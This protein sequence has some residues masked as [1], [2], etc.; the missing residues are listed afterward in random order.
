MLRCLEPENCNSKRNKREEETIYNKI[1]G[2]LACESDLERIK[3]IAYSR[4]ISI[5]QIK[6]AKIILGVMEKKSIEKMV[7]DLRVSPNF[8]IN[9]MKIFAVAGLDYL[10]R[11]ARKPTSREASIEKCCLFLK[12]V[13]MITLTNGIKSV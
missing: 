10:N 8:I 13:M 11:P 1:H 9:S 3:K 2:I 5:W 12:I 4:T 7:I 6:R